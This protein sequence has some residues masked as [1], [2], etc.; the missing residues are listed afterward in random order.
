MFN[1]IFLMFLGGSFQI[2][3][4]VVRLTLDVIFTHLFGNKKQTENKKKKDETKKKN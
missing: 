1:F 3:E 2:K 4:L